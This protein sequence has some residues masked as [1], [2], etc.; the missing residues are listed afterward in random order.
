MISLQSVFE[1]LLWTKIAW[2][3]VCGFLIGLERHLHRKPLDIRMSVL[4]CLGT[5]TFVHLGGLLEGVQ[6]ASRVLGQVIT[7]IGFLGAG[8]VITRQGHVTGLTTAAV[9][10]VL[11]GVGSA[12]GF[13]LYQIAASVTLATVVVLIVLHWA[14]DA[15]EEWI[16]SRS[17]ERPKNGKHLS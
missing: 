6:D 7:G 5:M 9:V 10:W 14:G 4:I 12:I 8:A 3:V 1:P 15:A 16:A 13:G 2:S 11:A 17:A